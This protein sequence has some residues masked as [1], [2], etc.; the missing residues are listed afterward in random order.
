MSDTFSI[1]TILSKLTASVDYVVNLLKDPA[2]WPQF[3]TIL[4]VF[5]IARW[6]VSPLFNRFLDYMVKLTSRAV[7]FRR[8]WMLFGI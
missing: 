4:V 8:L 5:L 2:F 6:L 7:S 1:D 3:I